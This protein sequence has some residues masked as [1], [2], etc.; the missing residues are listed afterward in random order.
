MFKAWKF[1]PAS[2]DISSRTDYI[3]GQDLNEHAY[4]TERTTGT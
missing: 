2:I 3:G 1:N 4:Q